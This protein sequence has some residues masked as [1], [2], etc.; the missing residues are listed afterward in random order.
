MNTRLRESELIVLLVNNLDFS[1]YAFALLL[2]MLRVNGTPAFDAFAILKNSFDFSVDN[3]R[4][5]FDNLNLLLGQW[6]EVKL[7][8]ELKSSLIQEFLKLHKSKARFTTG[9]TFKVIDFRI[10]DKLLSI[11]A[12][13]RQKLIE[14]VG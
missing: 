1:N 11:V 4:L 12:S 3:S 13:T 8:Q 6:G 2:K 9:N 7:S 14:K 5:R 10:D